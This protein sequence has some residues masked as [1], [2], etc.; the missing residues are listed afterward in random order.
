[1]SARSADDMLMTSKPTLSAFFL[2][3]PATSLMRLPQK[4]IAKAC[5][6]VEQWKENNNWHVGVVPNTEME[7][8]TTVLVTKTNR[9]IPSSNFYS[10]GDKSSNFNKK[11]FVTFP[12]FEVCHTTVYKKWPSWWFTLHWDSLHGR[13]PPTAYCCQ[14][15]SPQELYLG[16]KLDI[17]WR[18]I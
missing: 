10:P 14:E 16:P 15:L 3:F 17:V 5:M 18:Y 4:S 7:M 6:L 12:W 9:C 13:V 11:H 8:K 1:M 2:F